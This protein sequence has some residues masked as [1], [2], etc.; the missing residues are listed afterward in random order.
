MSHLSRLVDEVAPSSRLGSR[1]VFFR[2]GGCVSVYWVLYLFW[3]RFKVRV[4]FRV[5]VL[6]VVHF[7]TIMK[8]D[9][10]CAAAHRILSLMCVL[11]EVTGSFI[12]Y[13]HF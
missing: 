10:S 6:G 7:V 1:D 9:V 2:V 13:T 5:C 12:N 11:M 3:A 8:R 4:Y